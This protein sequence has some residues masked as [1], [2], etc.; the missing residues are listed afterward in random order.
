[1]NMVGAAQ[2][3]RRVSAAMLAVGEKKGCHR[4]FQRLAQNGENGNL[5]FPGERA[6]RTTPNPWV[7]SQAAR[8]EGESDQCRSVLSKNGEKEQ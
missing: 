4:K 5:R 3:G 1:V 7:G 6:L 2:K 8:R